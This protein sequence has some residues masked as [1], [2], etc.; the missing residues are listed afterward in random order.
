LTF[1]ILTLSIL[2]FPSLEN[3]IFA[4]NL[5]NNKAIG[6]YLARWYNLISDH[7]AVEEATSA[8]D[9]FREAGKV[10]FFF[11]EEILR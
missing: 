4:R 11:F 1:T 7:S 5:K 10:D 6:P 9:A 3:A 8:L 2:P